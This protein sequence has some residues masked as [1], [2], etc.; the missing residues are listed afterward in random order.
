MKIIG[1]MSGT[2]ADGVDAALVAIEGKG[3]STQ[4]E[5]LG[6]LSKAYPD[7][8][9]QEI[10]EL[11]E[12]GRVDRICRM[13]TILGELFANVSLDVCA[14]SGVEIEEVDL[15]GSHG[16]T[17]HH[18]PEREEAYGV[19]VR[20]TLQIGDP[21]VIAERTGVTTVSDFRSR[22]L[23]AGGEGAPVVP[24]VDYLL[25]RSE[26]RGRAMLNI[27]GIAN[28][29][30]LPAGCDSEEVFAFDTGPGNMVMD[31]L[32]AKV[33]N[34][35]LTYDQNGK[36]AAAGK[37]NED[38]LNHLMEDP[39]LSK[40]PPKS[41]GREAFGRDF[42]DQVLDWDLSGV[43]LIKTAA[44]FTAQSIA[45]AFERFVYPNH[46]IHDLIVSG[47][48]SENP[49]LMNLI[50]ESFTGLD[51]GVIDSLGV[52]SEA[53]EALAFAVLANETRSGNPGNLPSVTGANR[54][55]IL[56]SIVPGRRCVISVD[57]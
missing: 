19:T 10:L 47:G 50:R 36:L 41:T 40:G 37:V 25:F 2:S 21:A 51:V 16:Q 11:C 39:Y 27:G 12:A 32:A 44:A 22:D 46:E 53:K 6:F 4:F 29:A 24:L 14:K 57:S 56:G 52:A 8:L 17:I 15:I 30:I 35:T 34:G 49:I 42:S 38:L 18:L 20:S 7:D 48:G 26:T 31:A 45:D 54:P 33:S 3:T 23:A 1:L 55:V 5:I 28:V 43:D 13:N 9:R